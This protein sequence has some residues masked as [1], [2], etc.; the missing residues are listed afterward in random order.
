MTNALTAI[1][2]AWQGWYKIV[3][4]IVIFMAFF[5]GALPRFSTRLH[6]KILEAALDCR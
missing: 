6:R 5:K 3:L 1:I 2:D 4:Y